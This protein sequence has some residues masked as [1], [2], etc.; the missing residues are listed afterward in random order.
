MR[1]PVA[2]RR[3]GTHDLA[4]AGTCAV[5]CAGSRHFNQAA[6]E[7]QRLGNLFH[8]PSTHPRAGAQFVDAAL[9]LSQAPREHAGRLC[10]RS[11]GTSLAQRQAR[12]LPTVIY[13]HC[14]RQRIE[15]HIVAAPA[16][17]QVERSQHRSISGKSEH[18]LGPHG[19]ER[20]T[21]CGASRTMRPPPSRRAHA[22]QPSLRLLVR[23]RFHCLRR[24]GKLC[25]KM[26][27]A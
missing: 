18:G 5:T 23:A 16:S 15:R 10:C 17:A 7:F 26:L 4:W 24:C 12:A 25:A 13:R 6:R 2:G 8:E 1:L 9:L 20:R 27:S 14:A 3:G 19:E 22:V 11:H 21:V